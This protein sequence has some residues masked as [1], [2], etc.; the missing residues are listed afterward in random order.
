MVALLIRN[1]RAGIESKSPRPLLPQLLQSR[2]AY[3]VVK[4][5]PRRSETFIA[6][7]P[8]RLQ[9]LE[10][11]CRQGNGIEDCER[12]GK[13]DVGV[14]RSRRLAGENVQYCRL[15]IKLQRERALVHGDFRQY[16]PPIS[17][18]W[19]RLEENPGLRSLKLADDSVLKGAY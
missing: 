15:S 1:H 17:L 7:L 13:C 18:N 8:S 11:R 12:R 5:T 3:S 16:R 9:H 4:I 19:I 2:N 6:D 10:F 14:L